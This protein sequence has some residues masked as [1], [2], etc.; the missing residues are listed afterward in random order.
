MGIFLVAY[1]TR[2]SSWYRVAV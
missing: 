1:A 2:F